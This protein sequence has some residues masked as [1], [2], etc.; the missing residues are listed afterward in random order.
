MH[1]VWEVS[2]LRI[3]KSHALPWLLTRVLTSHFQQPTGCLCPGLACLLPPYVQVEFRALPWF[4]L[5]FFFSGQ[6]TAVSLIMLTESSRKVWIHPL[7]TLICTKFFSS[8]SSL[9]HLSFQTF[10]SPRVWILC[11]VPLQITFLFW[12]SFASAL[13]NQTMSCCRK[14]KHSFMFNMLPVMF[15]SHPAHPVVPFHK[16]KLI[17]IEECTFLLV[18]HE[19][20]QRERV[21]AK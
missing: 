20:S 16:I 8:H 19:M 13:L 4:L 7:S 1:N 2:V 6:W 18:P 11:P 3:R 9:Y 15:W 5:P 21:H 14:V 12:N 10:P 17:S